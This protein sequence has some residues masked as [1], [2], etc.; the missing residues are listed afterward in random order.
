MLNT[1]HCWARCRLSDSSIGKALIEQR[2]HLTVARGGRVPAHHDPD[3]T[4]P[5]ANCR[6]CEIEAACVYKSGFDA[7]EARTR[8]QQ[9]IMVS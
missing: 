7:V 4:A 9:M 5:V 6:G 2:C 1:R 8:V 3:Q